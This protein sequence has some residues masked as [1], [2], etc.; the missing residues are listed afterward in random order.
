MPL[1]GEAKR[2][3]Q[4]EWTRKRRKKWFDANGP[5]VKCGSWFE[6]EADHIDPSTKL[7]NPGALWNLSDK[8]P[9]RIAELAKLQVLC[10]DCHMEKTIEE[11]SLD[12]IHGTYITGYGRGCR[13]ADCTST[14]AKYWQEY[15]MRKDVH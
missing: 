11:S 10:S 14:V 15:R 1:Y 9:V 13:C 4:K 6:L 8:N 7:M 3:Y 5:C 2:Q 12:P